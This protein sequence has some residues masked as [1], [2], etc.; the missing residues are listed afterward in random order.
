MEGAE[1]LTGCDCHVR[2][3]LTGSREETVG[4]GLGGA[5]EVGPGVV[6]FVDL[7]DECLGGGS[8]GGGGWIEGWWVDG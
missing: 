3:G 2:G 6:G 8:R 1:G 7:R 5:A 4:G